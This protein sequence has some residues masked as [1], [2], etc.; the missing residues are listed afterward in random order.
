MPKT[1]WP[2]SVL[3]GTDCD[4]RQLVDSLTRLNHNGQVS[5]TS[6]CILAVEQD[7][8]LVESLVM[9]IQCSRRSSSRQF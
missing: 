9:H 3:I 5:G 4:F 7:R 1:C 6:R 2:I 8:N